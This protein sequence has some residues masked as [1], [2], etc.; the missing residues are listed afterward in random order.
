LFVIFVVV[1]I[2]CVDAEIRRIKQQQNK[3]DAA[4]VSLMRKLRVT[5]TAEEDS[6]VSNN[7]LYLSA[8]AFVVLSLL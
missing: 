8:T 1:A 4:A 2:C 7:Y 5:W 3:K 6:L